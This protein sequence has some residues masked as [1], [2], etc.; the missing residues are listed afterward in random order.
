MLSPKIEPSSI[1]IAGFES[2]LAATAH[3]FR[4]ARAE[5]SGH[6]SLGTGQRT[7]DERMRH[8]AYAAKPGC[9]LNGSPGRD[10]A[11]ASC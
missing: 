8:N 4:T 1:S 3:T 5:P 11:E 2:I 9:G 6:R 7:E 10:P